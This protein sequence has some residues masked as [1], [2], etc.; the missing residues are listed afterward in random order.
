MTRVLLFYDVQDNRTRNK[1]VET[2]ED[3]GLDREQYS[4]F[5]GELTPRQLRALGREL[6][7]LL[8][9]GGYILLVPIAAPEWRKRRQ[10]GAPIHVQ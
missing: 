5:M 9:S 2:C 4:V 1:I 6:A 7:H 10:I 3:Y 8:E